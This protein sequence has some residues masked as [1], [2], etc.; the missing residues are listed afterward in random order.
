EATFEIGKAGRFLRRQSQI[1]AAQAAKEGRQEPLFEQ[2]DRFLPVL[3]ADHGELVEVAA[4]LSRREYEGRGKGRTLAAG[5]ASRR[6]PRQQHPV[7]IAITRF[8][9]IDAPTL[10]ADLRHGSVLA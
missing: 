4:G 8:R 3:L 9:G 5:A 1:S 6:P 2:L 10:G 7:E